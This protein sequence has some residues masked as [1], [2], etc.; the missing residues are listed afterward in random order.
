[1]ADFKKILQDVFL[2]KEPEEKEAFILKET[3]KEKE[4]LDS[5]RT[6]KEENRGEG[7]INRIF[8]SKNKKEN[9]GEDEK[10][11]EVSKN[12][13]KNLEYIKTYN[14]SD[15]GDLIIREFKVVA[16]VES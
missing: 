9:K 8:S 2:F 3:K 10:L 15:N 14:Y 13:K 5:T 7:I 12:I 1:M 11:E 6:R 4:E 16:E